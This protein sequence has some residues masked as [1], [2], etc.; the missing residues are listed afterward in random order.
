MWTEDFNQYSQN[1][2]G[3]SESE[4]EGERILH[5]YNAYV[6]VYVELYM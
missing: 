2:C 6:Y 5:M 4:R 3:E 1:I